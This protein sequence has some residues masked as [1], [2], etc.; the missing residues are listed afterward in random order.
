M[1]DD[2]DAPPPLLASSLHARH[3]QLAAQSPQKPSVARPITQRQPLATLQANNL[4]PVAPTSVQQTPAKPT[5]SSARQ[6][7][8]LLGA[9]FFGLISPEMRRISQGGATAAISPPSISAA[10]DEAA[11]G[12]SEQ[13]QQQQSE[14]QQLLPPLADEDVPMLGGNLLSVPG[15]TTAQLLHRSPMSHCW[16]PPCTVRQPMARRVS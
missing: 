10:L 13:Q 7:P 15:T 12:K 2:D 14:Q 3:A 5:V 6:S 8:G 16:P 9:C 1:F 11:E 4:Q